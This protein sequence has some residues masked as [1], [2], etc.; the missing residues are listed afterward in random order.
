MAEVPKVP[1]ALAMFDSPITNEPVQDL[2]WDMLTQPMQ[3]PLMPG[4]GP[5]MPG[6]MQ[7]P[8]QMPQ[9]FG[10]VQPTQPPF[11]PGMGP[12]PDPMQ[13]LMQQQ[14]Q[15]QMPGMT[16]GA[17]TPDPYSDGPVG[18]MVKGEIDKHKLATAMSIMAGG[19]TNPQMAQQ[20]FTQQQQIE[21]RGDIAR[22]QIDMQRD[23]TQVYGQERAQRRQDMD[24][25]KLLGAITKAT[26]DMRELGV[27]GQYLE[28][29]GPMETRDDVFKA[30]DFIGQMGSERA[31]A[32]DRDNWFKGLVKRGTPITDDTL[33]RSRWKDD[34]Q[35]KED[36]AEIQEHVQWTIDRKKAADQRAQEAH[37][38]AQMLKRKRLNQIDK[39]DPIARRL[40]EDRYKVIM[41]EIKKLQADSRAKTRLWEGDR[42]LDLWGMKEAREDEIYDIDNRISQL[43]SMLGFMRDEM[44]YPDAVP[45]GAGGGGTDTGAP[46]T[47][48]GAGRRLVG[49]DEAPDLDEG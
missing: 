9:S 43:Y 40:V 46:T 10:G 21:Q 28:T 48:P 47:A 26:D 30:R 14:M 19:F 22:E 39:N 1:K 7:D 38:L 6:Q 31:I 34:P 45:G 20:Q 15:P 23:R 18:R 13:M 2:G 11:Q 8:Y 29:H 3:N 33:T 42:E 24:D 4:M 44:D 37:E 49:E 25:Y 35:A 5:M 41:S 17:T 16:P 36:F 27:Y 12:Q 32:E